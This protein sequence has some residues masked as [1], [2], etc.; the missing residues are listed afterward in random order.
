[1]RKELVQLREVEW[2][3]PAE[4]CCKMKNSAKF[5]LGIVTLTNLS[6]LN[7]SYFSVSGFLH[8]FFPFAFGKES[9]C[10]RAFRIAV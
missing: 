5:S 1:M 10:K 2:G 3:G 6:D 9:V 4:P 7:L 8:V